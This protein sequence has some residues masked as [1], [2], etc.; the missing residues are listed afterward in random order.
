MYNFIIQNERKSNEIEKRLVA[1]WMP[2]HENVQPA[3][4]V[5]ILIRNLQNKYFRKET[6]SYAPS[7]IIFG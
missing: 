4:K 7:L 2:S 1:I 5:F 6:T 3:N